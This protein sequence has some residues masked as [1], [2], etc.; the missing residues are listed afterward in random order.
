MFKLY[1]MFS[2]SQPDKN[3]TV[4]GV[5]SYQNIAEKDPCFVFK[6]SLCA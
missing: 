6:F 1:P 3:H 2:I 5:D 4:V